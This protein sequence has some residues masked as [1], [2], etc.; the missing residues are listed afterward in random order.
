LPSS[1]SG[2]VVVLPATNPPANPATTLT[3]IRIA[4]AANFYG[5][6]QDYLNIYLPTV[7]KTATVCSNATGTFVSDINAHP[8]SPIYD[9]FY[10]ADN[11]IIS[12]D[13]SN[14]VPVT[15]N[16]QPCA[17]THARLYAWGKPVLFAYRT[18]IP[19]ISYLLNGVPSSANPVYNL[20]VQTPNLPAIASLSIKTPNANNVAVAQSPAAPYGV[21]ALAIMSA[22]SANPSVVLNTQPDVG[23]AF[24]AVGTGSTNSGFVSKSQICEILD[25]VSYAE[26]LDYKL[27]Q[28]VTRFT[29][30]SVA[31]ELYNKVLNYNTALPNGLTWNEFLDDHCYGTLP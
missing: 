24:D 17:I 31:T 19:D 30:N 20:T 1:C 22:M 5:P 15:C 16:T 18:T 11:R 29:G 3:D 13:P 6:V 9:L 10:A 21:Q 26:F 28:Y 27:T 8:A 25:K 4:V 7:G 14:S 12:Y 23:A 2:D